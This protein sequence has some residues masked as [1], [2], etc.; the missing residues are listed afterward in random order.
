MP[1]NFHDTLTDYLI[2]I[3]SETN[4][5]SLVDTLELCE[6]DESLDSNGL[7]IKTIHEFK[8]TPQ[9]LSRQ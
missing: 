2:K 7:I 8:R 1:Q 6:V 3:I 4:G 5:I 9:W